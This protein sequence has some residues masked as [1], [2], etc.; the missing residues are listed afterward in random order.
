MI[1]T[2]T[3]IRFDTVHCMLKIFWRITKVNDSNTV[4]WY[5]YFFHELLI[6]ATFISVILVHIWLQGVQKTL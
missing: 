5:R 2:F 1:Y 4:Y 6:L 3:G